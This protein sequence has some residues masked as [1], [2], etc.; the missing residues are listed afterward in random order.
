MASLLEQLKALEVHPVAA[1]LR[2]P[3]AAAGGA[4]AQHR[5]RGA[6]GAAAVEPTLQ[7]RGEPQRREAAEPPGVLLQVGP[8]KSMKIAWKRHENG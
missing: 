2:G 1:Q 8:R 4:E 7:R 5:A 3:A 6:V